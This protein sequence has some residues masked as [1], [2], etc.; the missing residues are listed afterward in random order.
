[1]EDKAIT[2]TTGYDSDIDPEGNGYKKQDKSDKIVLT[3]G[4]FK[5]KSSN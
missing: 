1:M 4:K 3:G 5:L 2:K